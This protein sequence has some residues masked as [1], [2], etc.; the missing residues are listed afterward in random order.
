MIM[1]ARVSM[2]E[3]SVT[4][5]ILAIALRHGER[6]NAKQIS[7]LY[8]VIGSLSS[9]VDNSVQF[10]W[11]LISEGTIAEGANLHFHRIPAELVCRECDTSYSP[12]SSLTCPKCDSS[13]IWIKSGQEFYLESIGIVEDALNEPVE[14]C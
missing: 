6:A 8:L 13:K 4:E 3:L 5:S 11:D 1:T 7:D 9:I 12:E 10:Y 14:S 2:H